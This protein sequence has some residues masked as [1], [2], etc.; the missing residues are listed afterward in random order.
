MRK[1]TSVGVSRSTNRCLSI[2][3]TYSTCRAVWSSSAWAPSSAKSPGYCARQD[4]PALVAWLTSRRSHL[5][6]CPDMSVDAS[7]S[8]DGGT[9]S[10]RHGGPG[11]QPA[12]PH[13]SSSDSWS[14]PPPAPSLNASCA[15]CSASCAGCCSSSVSRSVSESAGGPAPTTE[16]CRGFFRVLFPAAGV[17]AAADALGRFFRR[18]GGIPSGW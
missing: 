5:K 3:P 13:S 12:S 2:G 11:T 7:R 4:E 9:L 18:L 8:S 16:L 17:E 1:N 6:L 14:S 10:G 15:G